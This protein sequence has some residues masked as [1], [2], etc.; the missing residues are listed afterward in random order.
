MSLNNAIFNTILP[1]IEN[2]LTNDVALIPTKDIA[3]ANFD[4]NLLRQVMQ[5]IKVQANFRQ[6][7]LFNQDLL[8]NVTKPTIFYRHTNQDADNLNYLIKETQLLLIMPLEYL[9]FD[10]KDYLGEHHRH[11]HLQYAFDAKE[12]LKMIMPFELSCVLKGSLRG[13]PKENA[14]LINSAH[15]CFS[16][17]IM[18]SPVIGIAML[19]RLNRLLSYITMPK[20]LSHFIL[21][22]DSTNNAENLKYDTLLALRILK[23]RYGVMVDKEVVDKL[24]EF[25][26]SL[27]HHAHNNKTVVLEI[28]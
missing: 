13:V 6:Y 10:V 15:P 20:M 7:Q 23:E 22:T 8:D 4:I 16:H 3:V 1:A 14:Y 19:G 26:K 9:V 12:N 24:V 21:Q 17:H 27:H 28:H 11:I 25:E 18:P 5:Y 2:F